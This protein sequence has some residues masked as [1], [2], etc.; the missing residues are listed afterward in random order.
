MRVRSSLLATASILVLGGSALGTAT[1]FAGTGG[2]ADYGTQPGFS[3]SNDHTSCAGHGAF[4]YVGKD[5]NEAGGADGAAT[6][7]NNSGLCGNPQR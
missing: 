5:Y 2:L 6:G 7:A 1:A 3:V 4:G